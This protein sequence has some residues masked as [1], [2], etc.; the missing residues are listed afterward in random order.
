MKYF[1]MII[2]IFLTLP[3]SAAIDCKNSV[4][5]VDVNECAEKEQ[6]LVEVTLNEV[7]KRVLKGIDIPDTEQEKFSVMKKSF[8]A[9]QRAW[10]KFR[11]A[12]CRALYDRHADGTIRTLM[13]IGCMQTHA[14]QRIKE[15]KEYAGP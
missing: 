14:E 5:T 2:T 11:E 15:L 6:K 4:S 10:I 1:L 8:I 7:Y 3:A 13:Y 12:D 9:A